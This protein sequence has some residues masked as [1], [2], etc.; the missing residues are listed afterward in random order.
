[1]VGIRG[2]S[3]TVAELISAG[4]KRISLAGSLYRAS[5]AGLVA[6]A[7]EIKQSGTFGY[8]DTAITTPDL[9]EFLRM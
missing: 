2:K 9:N 3:F 4:V 7:R 6:A 5:M 1:M 8:L